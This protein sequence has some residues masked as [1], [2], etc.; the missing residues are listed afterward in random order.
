MKRFIIHLAVAFITFTISI[1]ATYLTSYIHSPR[2]E[3]S[4]ISVE[5]P[6]MLLLRLSNTTEGLRNPKES[7]IVAEAESF[8]CSNGY[9]SSSVG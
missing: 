4:G 9:I 3:M 7:K 6:G 5:L 8:I 1:I 2:D